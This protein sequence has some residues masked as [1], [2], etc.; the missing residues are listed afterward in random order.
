MD[1]KYF[2]DFG[3]TFIFENQRDGETCE[4]LA[5]IDPVTMLQ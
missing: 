3:V 5:I 1:Y 4:T 2:E